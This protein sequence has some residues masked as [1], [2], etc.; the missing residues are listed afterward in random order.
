MDFT[1]R[2]FF[3]HLI[4]HPEDAKKEDYLKCFYTSI[5]LGIATLGI[6]PLAV[7]IG[8]AAKHSYTWI[9]GKLADKEK[10]VDTVKGKV[11]LANTSPKNVNFSSA[12]PFSWK[13]NYVH[14]DILNNC[15][16]KIDGKTVALGQP[17]K[18]EK[19]TLS[20]NNE[21]RTETIQK[22]PVVLKYYN[23]PKTLSKITVVD[24]RTDEAIYEGDQH[25]IALNF[26][27]AQHVGGGPAIYR[28]HTS[29]K[30]MRASNGY[31]AKAQEESLINKS[32]LFSSL[33]LLET[34][35]KTIKNK[36]RNCYVNG[37]FDSRNTAYT[38]DNKLFG[39]Q[40]AD[41]YTT[42]FLKEPC[43]VSFITSAANQYDNTQTINTK[44][45]MIL[46]DIRL[47]IDTHLYAAAQ[48]AIKLKRQDP[49]KPVKLILGA[50]GCGAFAPKNAKEYAEAVAFIYHSVLTHRKYTT[51]G[52]FDEIIFAIPK[53]EQTD[54]N[55][56]LVINFN[57]F[58]QKFKSYNPNS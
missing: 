42:K 7:G 9:T 1:I 29:G 57:A 43:S 39:L 3:N 27:N 40:D 25:K 31:S 53:M 47:R 26:A 30:I 55:N 33:T 8:W 14:V 21:Q 15:S 52:F 16:Y 2:N 38:S 17:K 54:E 12:E 11:L 48:K 51:D 35:V 6:L 50:F 13:D 28:D 49:K 44:D 58:E 10:K 32:D 46:K 24:Q 23:I 4:F 36:Q 45:K 37:G 34:E 22:L 18:P 56:P 41:F 20:T 5:A 19:I